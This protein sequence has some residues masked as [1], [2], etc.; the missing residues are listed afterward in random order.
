MKYYII[1]GQYQAY[2]YGAA[3]TLEE[4]KTIAEENVEYWDNWQ[5]WH[6]PKIYREADVE[7]IENFYGEGYAP[8]EGRLPVLVGVLGDDEEIEWLDF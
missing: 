7:A 3:E 4:A 1:G 5:G 6:V 8:I 2:C